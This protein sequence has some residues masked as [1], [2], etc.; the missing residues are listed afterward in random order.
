MCENAR[1]GITVGALLCHIRPM[2][3]PGKQHFPRSAQITG[4][5]LS[6]LKILVGFIYV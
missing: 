3:G 5:S 1:H 4:A 6:L 2:S